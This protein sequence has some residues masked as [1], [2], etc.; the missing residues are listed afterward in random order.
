MR[1]KV[2]QAQP[3]TGP[4]V[5]EKFRDSNAHNISLL[6]DTQMSFLSYLP[7]RCSTRKF[8]NFEVFVKVAR[9]ALSVRT[10]WVTPSIE[11]LRSHQTSPIK[12]LTCDSIISKMPDNRRPGARFLTRTVTTAGLLTSQLVR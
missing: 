5:A 4:R 7:S 1:N 2:V 9:E 11:F 8:V 10:P 3:F 12:Y 6:S